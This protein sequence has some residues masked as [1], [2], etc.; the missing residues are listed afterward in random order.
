MHNIIYSKKYI[1]GLHSIPGIELLKSLEF[2]KCWKQSSVF[3][4]V[5]ES[6]FGKPLGN[7]KMEAGDDF[8]TEGQW[9]NHP[10]VPNKN[11][12]KNPKGQSSKSFQWWTRG[13]DL[14]C[15]TLGETM[16]TLSLPTFL[17]LCI[18]SSVC[19]SLSFI[20]S[21]NK[22]VNIIKGFPKFCELF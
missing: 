4:Y 14:V 15:G 21:L 13:G 7:L 11:L 1:F 17:A 6:T 18:S 12:N 2:P 10:C 20:K 16:K 8:I 9:F 19:S 22:L 3:C 5:N